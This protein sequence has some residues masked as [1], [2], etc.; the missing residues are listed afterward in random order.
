[1]IIPLAG[2]DADRGVIT[3]V[4][5]LAAAGLCGARAFR[6][7]RDGLYFGAG[8]LLAMVTISMPVWFL[9]DIIN[10]EENELFG[11]AITA[12]FGL[13]LTIFAAVGY[14]GSLAWQLVRAPRR[15]GTA[16]PVP[17]MPRSGE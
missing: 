16:E 2:T 7:L 4:A 5:A 14:A 8:A 12:S 3:L 11:K 9:V 1:L 17:L 15:S 10:Q 13:Y 6:G